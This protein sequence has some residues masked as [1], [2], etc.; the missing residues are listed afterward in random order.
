M[1]E[2]KAPVQIELDVVAES[3]DR[4]FLLVGECKWTEAEDAERL[5]AQLLR[6]A[7]LLPFA[8]GHVLVPVLFLKRPPM[9]GEGRVFLPQDVIL[10]K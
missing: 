6:K 7:R 8:E 5:T 4:R 10:A 1:D 2:A 9:R 3:M